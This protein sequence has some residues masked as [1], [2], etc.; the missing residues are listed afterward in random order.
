MM[1]RRWPVSVPDD[2]SH[3]PFGA[4]V[5]PLPVVGGLID[6]QETDSVIGLAI[7]VIDVH[8]GEVIATSTAERGATQKNSSGGGFAV[9]GHIPV[10]IAG[11]AGSSTTGFHDRLLDSA[12]QEAVSAE[13]DKIVAAAPRMTRVS[14]PGR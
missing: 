13:A 2:Q 12:M 9:V 14:G 3:V 8:T 1:D 5:L 6:K 10:P 4:G 7:R 11:G